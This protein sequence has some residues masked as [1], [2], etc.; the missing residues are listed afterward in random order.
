[1]YDGMSLSVKIWETICYFE[2]IQCDL[3][4]EM[5]LLNSIVH[6]GATNNYFHA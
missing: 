4:Q 2:L 3:N 1:M 6:G 5:I